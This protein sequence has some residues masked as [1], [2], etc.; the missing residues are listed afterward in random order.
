MDASIPA[1]GT[2]E[3][4]EVV[5]AALAQT[6]SRFESAISEMRMAQAQMQVEVLQLG[7]RVDAAQHLISIAEQS[8]SSSLRHNSSA[9]EGAASPEV[10]T[11]RLDDLSADIRRE[12]HRRTAAEVLLQR[13]I[14]EISQAVHQQEPNT[15]RAS[16]EGSS[17]R[18]SC[19]TSSSMVEDL[20]Q[21][22]DE[23]RASDSATLSCEAM[24][25]Q[26]QC[27][28]VAHEIEGVITSSTCSSSSTAPEFSEL[29]RDAKAVGSAPAREAYAELFAKKARCFEQAVNMIEA[30]AASV[31][32]RL[33]AVVSES[34]AAMRREACDRAQ[35][36]AEIQRALQE[37]RNAS[38]RA[39]A[40]LPHEP[41]GSAQAKVA[42]PRQSLGSGMTMPSPGM[43]IGAPGGDAAGGGIGVQRMSSSSLA[44][45]ATGFVVEAG[46]VASCDESSL[47]EARTIARCGS[48]SVVMLG[49]ES[50]TTHK[51][52][53]A[54]GPG[55]S[56]SVV[57]ASSQP[58]H[59]LSHDTHGSPEAVIVAAQSMKDV[60][61]SHSAAS[62]LAAIAEQQQSTIP[63]PRKHIVLAPKTLGSTNSASGAGT[64]MASSMMLTT[65][66]STA[67]QAST[68]GGSALFRQVQIQGGAPPPSLPSP[69][70]GA[71]GETSRVSQSRLIASTPRPGKQNTA[72]SP[73][74]HTPTQ[75]QKASG[76]TLTTSSTLVRQGAQVQQQSQQMVKSLMPRAG[77][78][79]PVACGPRPGSV[80]PGMR[81]PGRSLATGSSVMRFTSK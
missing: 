76:Q 19:T 51:V 77:D 20:L 79:T 7:Q 36:K 68:Y 37:I 81:V 32:K 1:L 27:Q 42:R 28:E 60:S 4:R 29:V 61:A 71:I 2:S 8:A 34:S 30:T 58:Q 67:L 63:S 26:A 43:P 80:P 78:A 9:A 24:A 33:E 46:S 75:H 41:S 73:Q 54:I 39:S 52:A 66:S 74:P 57:R 35:A 53:G 44:P 22:L 16:I 49:T 45:V 69:S 50:V 38:D 5:G 48:E 64:S 21:Q 17:S 31:T 10:L 47:G 59:S 12:R 11:G 62:D 18:R 3:S 23:L 65:T 56:T 40:T 6:V 13:A 14:C 15:G 70:P 25:V 55:Q 72:S